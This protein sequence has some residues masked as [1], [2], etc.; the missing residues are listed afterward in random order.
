[1]LF[2]GTEAPQNCDN[3]DSVCSRC[4]C[5]PPKLRR[6]WKSVSEIIII[7]EGTQLSCYQVQYV[8]SKLCN[9]KTEFRDVLEEQEPG[10]YLH[11]AQKRTYLLFDTCVAE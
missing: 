4:I 8:A 2:A 1:M 5:V 7:K 11:C 9:K 6:T 3:K 10:S